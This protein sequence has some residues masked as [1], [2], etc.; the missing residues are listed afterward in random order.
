[1]GPSQPLLGPKVGQ[2]QIRGAQRTLRDGG[3]FLFTTRHTYT[4]NNPAIKPPKLCKHQLDGWFIGAHYFS[5]LHRSFAF[6]FMNYKCITKLVTKI[7]IFLPL[8]KIEAHSAKSIPAAL[9]RDFAKKRIY[10]TLQKFSCVHFKILQC[11]FVFW[12]PV[13]WSPLIEQQRRLIGR[14]T[15][16]GKAKKHLKCTLHGNVFSFFWQQ[17]AK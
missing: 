14:F 12:S 10:R 3:L 15:R 16:R 1:M 4:D 7:L 2:T 11:M 6:A 13:K 9:L 8:H 5:D 17:C